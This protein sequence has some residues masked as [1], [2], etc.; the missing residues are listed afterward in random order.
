MVRGDDVSDD[1]RP[2]T[3]VAAAVSAFGTNAV[4]VVCALLNVLIIARAL[5]PEGRGQVAF[6][7]VVYVLIAGLA[8]CGL[9]EANANIGATRADR[10]ASLLT[11][12]VLAATSLGLL[13]ALLVGALMTLVP[14]ARGGVR[15]ELLLITLATL[16]VGLLYEYLKYLLQS[17]YRF[18]ATN[19]GWVASPAS[20]VLVNGALALT[21][22]LSVTAVIVVYIATN[23]LALLVL[24][25]AALRGFGLGRPDLK[26]ACETAS[27]GLKVHVSK[28]MGLGIY[29]AD[30]WLLGIIAGPFELG[31]Y[32]IAASVIDA[33]FYIAGVIVLV[34]RP[35]L[36]RAIP[37]DAAEFAAR[38]FRRAALLST[39]AGV[40]LFVTAPL[41][42]VTLFGEPFRGAIADLRLLTFAA[43]GVLAVDLFTNAIIS[44]RRPL[45]A[46]IGAGVALALTIGLNLLLTP[47]F[48]GEGAA[49]A[50]SVAYTVGGA[51]LGMTFLRMFGGSARSLV[52]RPDDAAWYWRKLRS[53]IDVLDRRS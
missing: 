39:G 49:I 9:E 35:H 51:V 20:S 17:D 8:T 40:A 19:L 30:Q 38:I 50:K 31:L 52:P 24:L 7:I 10:R 53:G 33:L 28:L 4:A 18:G 21:G 1:R 45:L 14:G 6:V 13:A 37:A 43:I 46:S 29:R 32:S 5:G 15:L 2:A 41:L 34:Q 11:N 42:I 47:S 26:L 16:P 23:V 3:L 27:F 12:S 36:V 22:Q 44:Q 25:V 48:G